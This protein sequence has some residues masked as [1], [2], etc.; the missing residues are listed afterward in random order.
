MSIGATGRSLI[1]FVIGVILAAGAALL[2]ARTWHAPEWRAPE[3]TVM[4]SYEVRPEIA[5]EVASALRS[6]LSPSSGPYYGRVSLSPSG[7]LLVVAP[8]SIQQG[9]EQVLKEVAAREPATTPSIHFEA[10]LVTASTGAPAD[11]PNLK[12]I[13]PALHALEQS[14][15]PAHFELLE[16]LTTQTRSGQES[17]VQG[18]YA[19]L[20]VT[21]SVL[22]G[23]KDQA[24]IAA[25]LEV[26]MHPHG[27]HGPPPFIR[28]QTELRPGELLVLGQS[29]YPNGPDAE[30]AIYYIVRATL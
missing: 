21:G 10:W 17:S 19:L 27:P 5:N 28:A 13:A 1:W 24:I 2:A 14:K 29:N 15:G 23:N 11:S 22:R 4:R 20:S 3:T 16:K 8:P 6:A 18:D 30:R 9:V 7:Q 25:L 12:E 26:T